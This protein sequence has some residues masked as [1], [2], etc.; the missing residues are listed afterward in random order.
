MRAR[1]SKMP[2]M[3]KNTNPPDPA[4]VALLS[5]PVCDDRPPLRLSEAGNKLLCDACGRAYPISPEGI[6]L[7]LPENG[8]TSDAPPDRGN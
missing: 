2:A 3:E 4:F 7:L 5:C 8:E 1:V 6:V